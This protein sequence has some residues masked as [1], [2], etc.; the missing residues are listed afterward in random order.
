MNLA[1]DPDNRKSEVPLKTA[2]VGADG[3]LCPLG[4]GIVTTRLCFVPAP[5]YRVDTPVPLSA[6]HQKL[7]GLRVRPH[8]LTSCGSSGFV[9]FVP[10]PGMLETRFV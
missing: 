7:V 5:S 1:G 8:E 2:P 4:T 3:E 10:T 6:T 9:G